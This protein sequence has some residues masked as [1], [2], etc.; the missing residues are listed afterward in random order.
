[1]MA[2]NRSFH[3]V[4]A[5]ALVL[6][7]L[8]C[9][10]YLLAEGQ[11]WLNNSLNLAVDNEFSLIIKSQIRAHNTTFQDPFLYFLEGGIGYKL[12]KNF[13]LNALYRRQ[14]SKSADRQV[15]ENRYVLETGWKTNLNKTFGFDWRFRWEIR[16]FEQDANVNH[17]CFRLYTRL[18][19]KIKIG[20]LNLKPF[21]ADEPFYDTKYD[22]FSQNRFYLGSTFPLGD[23]VEYVLSYLRQDLKG[24]DTNH[25]IYTGFN[26]R[27]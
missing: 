21:I 3:L 4:S 10:H 9:G 13:F 23:K 7:F 8:I 6:L 27:F 1:M 25:I 20:E 2:K 17:L 24:K 15:N 12:P 5:V 22:A 18:T 26:L 19:A 14:T 11:G 16:R